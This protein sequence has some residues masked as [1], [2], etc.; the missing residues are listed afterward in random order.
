M[1][2]QVGT[3]IRSKQKCDDCAITKANPQLGHNKCKTH[4]ACTGDLLWNPEE[5]DICILHRKNISTWTAE[6]RKQ[7][8][9]NYYDMLLETSSALSTAERTWTFE[10]TLESFFT[11]QGNEAPEGE[12]S[13]IPDNDVSNN[14]QTAKQS[15]LTT[16]DSTTNNLLLQMMGSIKELSG[17]LFNMGKETAQKV[18]Q[19][20]PAKRRRRTPSPQADDDDSEESDNDYHRSRKK[21]RKTINSRKNERRSHKRFCSR[22]EFSRLKRLK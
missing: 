4:R 16:G 6:R 19:S 9:K 2:T 1:E 18:E 12:H 22:S 20:K 21:K 14:T 7:P 15:D 13:R 5:C 17:I 3:D 8:I 10:E 11:I